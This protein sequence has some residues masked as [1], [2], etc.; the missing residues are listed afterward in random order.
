MKNKKIASI[1]LALTICI[2]NT[3]C[4]QVKNGGNEISSSVVASSFDNTSEVLEDEDDE[5]DITKT[6]QFFLDELSK[7][8]G[9][10]DKIEFGN[11]E[12]ENYL[13]TDEI[14]KCTDKTKWDFETLFAKIEENSNQYA[15]DHPEVHS[16]FD[17]YYVD[18]YA[19]SDDERYYNLEIMQGIREG[20]I[21]EIQTAIENNDQHQLHQFSTLKI[22]FNNSLFK[23]DLSTTTGL[24]T[25]TDNLVEISIDAIRS[26]Y[27]EYK[28][29]NYKTF[30]NDAAKLVVMHEMNHAK[31]WA[32]QD[33]I[34]NGK[35]IKFDVRNGD[36]ISTFLEAN[37]ENDLYY[38]K[39]KDK[40]PAYRYHDD[41]NDI[42]YLQA[43]LYGNY[44]EFENLIACINAFDSNTDISEFYDAIYNNDKNKIYTM[45]NASTD[46]EKILLN[47]IMYSFDAFYGR[48]DYFQKISQLYNFSDEFTDE[49]YFKFIDT[50]GNMEYVDILKLSIKNLILYNETNNDLSLKENLIL[51]NFY[52]NKIVTSATLIDYSDDFT[53]T[54]YYLYRELYQGVK[55]IEDIF[56]RYLS[57]RYDISLNDIYLQYNEKDNDEDWLISFNDYFVGGVN[58]TTIKNLLE[59]FSKLKMLSVPNYSCY[60]ALESAVNGDEY[61]DETGY[62]TKSKLNLRHLS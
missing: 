49:E 45:L 29:Y 31:E 36:F 22:V 19:S 33:E 41:S 52:L 54:D 57:K 50:L 11:E 26:V 37:A 27:D 60:K 20:I 25:N 53:T 9:I 48:N 61:Y 5:E 24:Y 10:E 4:M 16:V 18:N 14:I 43:K 23:N 17:L 34:E 39:L 12:I 30:L 42:A 2:Q 15:L 55:Q 21:S 13:N 8:K 56:F 1:L 44:C 28:D 46:E 47:K 7:V 62:G 35:S 3:A 40:N 58:R 38:G 32:C 51:Y 6:L 59:K